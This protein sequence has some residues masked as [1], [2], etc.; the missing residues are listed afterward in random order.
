MYGVDPNNIIGENVSVLLSEVFRF[1]D[2]ITAGHQRLEMSEEG[3]LEERSGGRSFSSLRNVEDV[4]DTQDYKEQKGK[5]VN[6]FVVSCV[7]FKYLGLV[8]ELGNH[9]GVSVSETEL[10]C[11]CVMM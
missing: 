11:I 4:E 3:N 10:A 1:L 5:K 6:I 7:E 8:S 2:E 9:D